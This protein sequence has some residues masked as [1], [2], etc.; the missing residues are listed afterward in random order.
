MTPSPRR[1]GKWVAVA[2]Q[3]EEHASVSETRWKGNWWLPEDPDD[4]KPGT[5]HY[6]DDGRLRLELIGGFSIEV[7]TPIA[8]GFAVS[9]RD[10]SFPVIHGMC[11]SER[12]TLLETHAVHSSGGYFG[13]ISDQTLTALRGLRGIHVPNAQEP[14]F[15]SAEVQLEYLLGW[16]RQRMGRARTGKPGACFA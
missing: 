9:L 10:P 5:L 2:G 16:A 12:F 4:T 15:D 13:D 7:Q 3:S 6:G 1:P 11:G 8:N 14:V